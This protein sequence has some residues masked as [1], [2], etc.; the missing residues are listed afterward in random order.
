M[1]GE[2][3]VNHWNVGSLER[4]LPG[5]WTPWNVDSLERGLPGMWTPWNVDFVEHGLPGTWALWNVDYCQVFYL[6]P[7][8]IFQAGTHTWQ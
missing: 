3:G 6:V 2:A 5:T 8:T 4:G 7:L 1:E